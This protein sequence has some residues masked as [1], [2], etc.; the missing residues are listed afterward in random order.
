MLIIG[1]RYGTEI[2]D[3]EFKGISY[4]ER[5]YRYAKE[6]G[7][8]ILA[9]IEKYENMS[10]VK[11][12]SGSSRHSKLIEFRKDVMTHRTVDFWSSTFELREKVQ[13][14]LH[15]EFIRIKRPGWVRAES[16]TKEDASRNFYTVFDELSLLHEAMTVS[17]LA[18]KTGLSELTVRDIIKQLVAD[19]MVEIVDAGG[20]ER[21]QIP[22]PNAPT[23]GYHI[24]RN[25]SK[26]IL[27]EGVWKDQK[28]YNGNEYNWTIKDENHTLVYNPETNDYD[29]DTSTE[30]TDYAQYDDSFCMYW[31]DSELE[32]EGLEHFYVADIVAKNGICEYVNIK[33][34]EDWLEEKEP[35]WLKM[36]RENSA[37]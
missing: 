31:M 14:S 28:L 24:F 1:H 17:D 20:D 35:R 30:I 33:K 19:E 15:K 8:P 13:D 34:L 32:Y 2:P 25:N 26:I 18:E 9:F 6:H 4:T 16:Q 3:G 10:E 11:R 12:E 7:I 36:Y 22:D 5:E 29:G 27:K 21:Y 23:D 37:D